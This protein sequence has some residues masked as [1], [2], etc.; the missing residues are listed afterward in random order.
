[1]S[2]WPSSA[3]CTPWPGSALVNLVFLPAV[4]GWSMVAIGFD[5]L[6]IYAVT[7]HGDALLADR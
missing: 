3:S 6:V 7:V 5:V 1:V 2:S 4:P